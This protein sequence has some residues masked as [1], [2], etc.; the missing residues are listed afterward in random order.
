[1]KLF[2]LRLKFFIIKVVLFFYWKYRN[3]KGGLMIYN[4]SLSPKSKLG[5]KTMV[6]SGTEVGEI[7]LGDYSYISGP[8]SYVEEAIIGK[9]CSIARQVVIGVSGHNY[10]W[11]TTS[12]IITSEKYGFI[13]SRVHEPQKSI[14]IIGNDVWIGMNSIIMRGVIIGDGAVVAAGSVVTTDVEPYSIVGGIPAKHIRFR[15]RNDQIQ[16]LLTLKWWDWEENKIKENS[17]LFYDIEAFLQK[18]YQK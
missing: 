12:P 6:R 18:H 7:T 15:F 17:S 4:S 14:P 11:V 5:K 1:M 10:E 16:K 3:L 2:L 13:E 8:G 9:Y